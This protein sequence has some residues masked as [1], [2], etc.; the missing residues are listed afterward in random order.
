VLILGGDAAAAR[1]AGLGIQHAKGKAFLAQP[2]GI[3]AYLSAAYGI[4]TPH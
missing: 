1:A 2:A 3:S 4:G